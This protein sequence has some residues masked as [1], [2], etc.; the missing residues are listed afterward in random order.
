MTNRLLI[1]GANGFFGRA[2]T[3]LAAPGMEIV[4]VSGCRNASA[5]KLVLD[6]RDKGNIRAVIREVRPTHVVNFASL[7]VTRDNSTLE[8]LLA[9]NTIGALNLVEALS[10]EGLA[11]H[12]ILFGTAY[13]YADLSKRIAES[14]RL[15]PKSNYAIS[16]TTLHYALRP[17]EGTVPLTFLRVF[18]VFGVGEPAERL[19]PY[20]L[21]K[22]MDGEEIPLTG[23]EQ[24]RDF[25]FIDDLIAILYRLV[26]L[27][28]ASSYGL[29]TINVG[30]G[31][32]TSLKTFIG[33]AA[34]ALERKGLTS[35][36]RFG[37]L[38]YRKQ[39]PMH[40]VA[41][42]TQLLNL[43]GNIPFTDLSLAINR[44]VQAL[45]E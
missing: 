30:T 15:E 38:P 42:N 20:I 37:A 28:I 40:C 26:A 22:T 17:Y 2:F 33:L 25:M 34:Q 29:R 5:S 6:L 12:T 21:R 41:D 43:L 9:V 35:K 44:T 10:E 7:G 16:K 13:E 32:G 1:T 19:I 18:N 11:A 3:R 31:T 23:G 4:A 14:A 45:H 27:P 8:S 39:D 36:L 24:Q